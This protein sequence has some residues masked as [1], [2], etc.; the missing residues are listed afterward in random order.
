MITEKLEGGSNG[1][2]KVTKNDGLFVTMIDF[3]G[4]YSSKE[5]INAMLEKAKVGLSDGDSYGSDYKLFKRMNYA[6]D[7]NTISDVCDRIISAIK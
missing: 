1:K 4:L 3:S 5:E 7:N 6:F 2:I